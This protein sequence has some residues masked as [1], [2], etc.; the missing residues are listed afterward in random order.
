[1]ILAVVKR[2]KAAIIKLQRVVKWKKRRRLIFEN[3]AMRIQKKKLEAERKRQEEERKKQEAELKKRKEE[4][5][6]LK[7]EEELKQQ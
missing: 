5:L 1:M 6:R 7:K 4:E 2:M 3:V